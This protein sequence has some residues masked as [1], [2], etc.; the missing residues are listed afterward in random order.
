VRRVL[1]TG[2]EGLVGTIV[3]T[4]LAGRY[5]FKCLTWQTR[6]YAD[7]VGDISDPAVLRRAVEGVDAVVHLAAASG[8]DATWD[9]VLPTNI[10]GTH[11][12]LEAAREAGVQ[13]VVLASS[14]HA[15][16]MYEADR[17]PEI[18]S[19]GGQLGL[20][21][22]APVRPDSLY[23]V[24]K[25]FAEAMGRYYAEQHGLHV[26]CLRIGSVRADDDPQGASL[27]PMAPWS[28]LDPA[29]QRR[30]QSAVWLSQRDCAGLIG[31]A[32]DSPA[33][34]FGIVY[35]VSD[36]EARFWDLTSAADLL[37]WQPEDGARIPGK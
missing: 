9:T 4:R 34:Q 7:V 5:E 27:L 26:L 36:N 8:V 11:N 18:Y 25:V 13:Q 30:R 12:V 16:G 19:V 35:G 22:D 31:A 10:V 23:G 24:S 20:S 32:L 6:D 33:V 17:V 15:V 14:N 29:S 3:R 1:L 37:G 28:Q 2:A 21:A